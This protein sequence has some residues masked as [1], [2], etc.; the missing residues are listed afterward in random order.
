[1]GMEEYGEGEREKEREE[2]GREGSF[3][4]THFCFGNSNWN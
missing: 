4:P 2:K 1:M 3:P